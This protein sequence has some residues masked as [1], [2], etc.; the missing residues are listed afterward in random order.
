MKNSDSSPSKA[1]SC[2]AYTAWAKVLC[3]GAVAAALALALPIPARA[4]TLLV[5][6]P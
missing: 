6:F 3:R 1:R 4:Q 5:R 2:Q